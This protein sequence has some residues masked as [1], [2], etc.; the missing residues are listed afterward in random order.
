M[1]KYSFI[2][3]HLGKWKSKGAGTLSAKKFVIQLTMAERSWQFN[4]VKDITSLSD[5]YASI[6]MLHLNEL[7]I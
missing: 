1:H 4:E 3:L 5:I 2:F 7:K 6:L